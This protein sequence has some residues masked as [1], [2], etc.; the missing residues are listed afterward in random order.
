MNKIKKYV[1]LAIIYIFNCF[2][3]KDN[4]IIF[5]SYYGSQ[6][7]CNPKYISE[8]IQKKC[9]PET[10]DIVWAFTDLR[11]KKYIEGVRKVKMMSFKYFYELCTSK[12]VITNFRTTDLFVK[13]KE[14]FYI[15]TWHSSLRLKQIEKDAEGSLPLQYIEMA[16]KDSLKCDLLL[17]GCRYSSDIFNR[18]FWYKGKVFEY[19][20]PRNDLFFSNNLNKNEIFNNLRIP[21]NHKIV[22][23]A[24]TFRKNNGVEA[25]N[26]EFARIIN[27]LKSRFGGDWTLLIKLHPHLISKSSKLHN[28]AANVIDVTTYDDIQELLAISDVLIS[29]YSSLIFDFSI[30]KRPCFL[31]IPDV[32]EYISNERKLYFDINQLPFITATNNKD[33]EMKIENFDDELYKSRLH[34]FLSDIGSFE[35]GRASEYLLN[36]ITETCFKKQRGEEY[37]AV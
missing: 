24:P 11:S 29:D 10:F 26:L 28:S 9:P 36:E 35:N 1:C 34:N 5:F 19:G 31:Y 3:I 23:Y 13:R 32:S 20:S 2:P 14:Q 15:Q 27:A 7:G 37:E 8:Y 16:K 6:Y 4:K 17:S 21:G 30:T 12:V 22:L 33:I 18:A 25:Y